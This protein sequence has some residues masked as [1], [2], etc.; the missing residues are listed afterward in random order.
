MEAT[1]GAGGGGTIAAAFAAREDLRGVASGATE[2]WLAAT[3]G[4]K[5]PLVTGAAIGLLGAGTALACGAAALA[6]A[7]ATGLTGTLGAAAGLLTALE[8]EV[9]AT[10]LGWVVGATFDA[11]LAAVLGA[12]L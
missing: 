6:T 1:T 9:W 12:A 4:A 10:P 2:G 8:A 3:A 5:A 11:G 7:L